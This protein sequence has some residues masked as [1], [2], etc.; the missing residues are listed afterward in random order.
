MCK[1]AILDL[2]SFIIIVK[3]TYTKS[4]TWI[5]ALV[6]VFFCISS[7][8][9]G[10]NDVANSYANSVAARTLTLPQV[11]VLAVF[12]EFIGAVA[13][14]AKVTNTIKN[15]IMNSSRFVNAPATLMLAMACAEAGSA[16]WLIIAT[17]YGFPVSTTQ[18]IVGAIVGA[19]I[20]SG[21]SVNW[22][23]RKNS[24][25]QVA[26]SW[27][28]SPIVAGIIASLLFGSLKFCIL[29]RRNPFQK[30]RRAIHFYLAF[31][32]G[33]LALF[34]VVEAPNLESI[35][36]MARGKVYGA[37]FGCFFGML[38]IS[39]IFF[40]PFFERRLVKKDP[41]VRFYHIPLG[42]LLRKN[43]C[44]LYFPARKDR[45]VVIDYYQGS[46]TVSS[47]VI[48]YTGTDLL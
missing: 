13:L 26:A 18:T 45:Q 17:K 11:G 30:A 20:A 8:G 16:A 25:S 37:I 28:I 44:W 32:A 38:A 2:I 4:Y 29:E 41:R 10:A 35:E 40:D 22:G 42:P 7:F 48:E 5:L 34:M 14:G 36:T 31:T 3:M 6:T 39:Y 19:G 46:S 23:W 27:I 47:M 12:T 21:A 15:G 43:N 33:V 1:I 24:I 9:N